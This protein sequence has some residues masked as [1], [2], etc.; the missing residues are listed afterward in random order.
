M[1]VCG[2]SQNHP[3]LCGPI[4]I[5]EQK[6]SRICKWERNKGAEKRERERE[7]NKGAEKR[8]REREC[9][10]LLYGQNMGISFL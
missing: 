2:L 9:T 1:L 10:L 6:L 7:R 4:K 5:Q 8:E 3:K